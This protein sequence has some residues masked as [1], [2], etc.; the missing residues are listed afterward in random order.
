MTRRA[1]AAAV[2]SVALAAAP[3]DAQRQCDLVYQTGPWTSVGQEGQRTINASGP[4]LVRCGGGEELRADSAVIYETMDEVH[5]FR[6]VDFQDPTRGLTSDQAIYNSRTGRLWATG[7]VVFTDKQRGS[8]L[9]GP[10]LEYWR[11]M[12]GRPQAQVIATQRPHM[13]VAPRGG[14]G[15]KPMEI[16][17]DRITTLGEQFVTAEGNVVI[18]G[19]RMDAWAAEAQYDDAA[20]RLE[21]RRD[22][23]AKGERYELTGDFIEADL[24]EGAIETV[25]SRGDARLVE[26]RLRVTG[27]QLRLFFVRDSLQRFVAGHAPGE[28]G[29]GRSVALAKGFRIEADSLDALTPGQRVERVVAIGTAEGQSWDTATVAAARVPA[30]APDT[31]QGAPVPAP[32]D[33]V[34]PMALG[35]RDLIFA[36][37]IIGFFRAPAADSAGAAAPADSVPVD[38]IDAPPPLRAD[39][40]AAAGEDE[41][42][43]ER[44]LAMGSA[45]SLYRME[46]SRDSTG[47]SP[48]RPGINYVI[49]DTIDLAFVAGEVETANIRGLKQGLYLDPDTAGAG[50]ARVDAAGTPSAGPGAELRPSP[51]AP[52]DG[53]PRPTPPGEETPP[54]APKTEPAAP[55]PGEPRPREGGRR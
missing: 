15:G 36:D 33:S 5:L 20:E 25:V 26:E 31:A 1:L 28:G 27:P 43:L 48:G 18:E 17:A 16:D 50:A 2:A 4:L 38:G 24:A 42:E 45:R 3:A 29:D 37:T 23:R 14:R 7:N 9:R 53:A 39:T 52:V 21:L 6:R 49:A 11:A 34:G 55:P 41:A 19:D 54:P 46:P 51:A 10:N 8:T 32:V 35:E 13:T 47:A 44:M 30:A 12:E 22:A 40:A